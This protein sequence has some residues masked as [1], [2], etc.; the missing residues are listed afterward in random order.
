LLTQILVEA[1]SQDVARTWARWAFRTSPAL[2]I[3]TVNFV[4]N[5]VAVLRE[6]RTAA[7]AR[8]PGDVTARTTWRWV[9]R[10]STEPRGRVLI[11]QGSIRIPVNVRVV[12][13]ALIPAAGLSLAPGTYEIEA[14]APGYLPATVTRE[15]LPGVTTVLAFNL[16]SA[17]VVSDVI[18]DDVRRHTFANVAPLTARRFG[19]SPAC[20]AGA[21]VSRDGLV[22][23]SYAAIRGADSIVAE[24]GAGARPQPIR[25][26]AYDVKADLAVVQVPGAARSDSIALASEIADGQSAWAL[27][28]ADCRTATEQRVRITQWTDRPRGA[29]ELSEPPQGAAPGSPLVDVR[30]LLA[31]VWSSGGS[32]VAAANITTLL[33]QARAA[34]AQGRL[35]AVGEVSRTENHLYGSIIVAS[36]MTGATA[37]I[38]PLETWQWAGLQTSGAAPFTFAGPLG[39]YK[40][41]VTGSGG[42]RRE[43]E[44]T[45]RAAAQ[46]RVVISLPKATLATQSQT[47][48]AIPTR[49]RSKLPWIIGAVGLG[50]AGAVAALAGGGSKGNGPVPNPNGSITVR[51]PVNPP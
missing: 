30:G 25:V 42:A 18:A 12:G 31:G 51:V 10:G 27:R 17:A 35:L 28:L 39:R 37:K 43:Q 11:D 32:A 20:I 4:A 44:I 45:I 50:G 36:D 3:D 16:T 21:Y 40:V 33:N 38:T 8:S 41:E 19:T 34:A 7:S 13:G 1:N 47:S 23:T 46:Q 2:A 49:K 6:A 22:L 48:A 29:L 14:G 24:A 9:A 26:A 15:I 5:A